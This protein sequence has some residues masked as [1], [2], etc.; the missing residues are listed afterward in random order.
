MQPKNADAL[1]ENG[2]ERPD[3]DQGQLA[4]FERVMMGGARLTFSRIP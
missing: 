4:A 1:S 3:D 2:I